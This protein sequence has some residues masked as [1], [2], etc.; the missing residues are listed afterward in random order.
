M[1]TTKSDEIAVMA[2]MAGIDANLLF[3]SALE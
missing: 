3:Q 2:V 1:V